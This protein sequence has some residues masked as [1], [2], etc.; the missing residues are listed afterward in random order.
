MK[1]SFTCP[2]CN[3][4]GTVDAIHIGKEARCKQCKARFTIRDP[5]D[6]EPD[7]YA[8]EGEAEAPAQPQAYEAAPEAV[9]VPSPSRESTF[10]ETPRRPRRSAPE[11]PPKR[12]AKS[13]SQSAW[14]IWLAVAGALLIFAL[15]G[16]A[17]FAP[18]GTWFVG[19]ILLVI[20]GLLSVLGFV[21][22]AYG[23]FSEDSLY[24]Y[25]Y[26]LIPLFT[27]YYMVT[28]WEDLWVW[29]ACSTVGVGL[30][31]LGTELIFWA[32]AGG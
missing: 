21:A 27:A 20:G 10:A 32:A 13:R 23:A 22:G 11:S 31:L 28:R 15:T 14:P 9:F 12:R 7:V 16:I 4:S 26:V 17:L 1:V 6:P 3:A 18:A 29:L 24:G 8:L 30:V 5:S 25:L 19:C 2:S